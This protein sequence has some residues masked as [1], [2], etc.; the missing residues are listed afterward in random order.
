VPI[1]PLCLFGVLALSSLTL[2]AAED[3]DLKSIEHKQP[4][5]DEAR[6]YDAWIGRSAALLAAQW[7]APADHYEIDGFSYVRYDLP[8]G[9]CHTV[10]QVLD[11]KVTAWRQYGK[12][13]R[14]P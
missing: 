7:G 9:D 5:A 2:R 3:Y 8:V 10:F 11:R 6:A 14:V 12:T 1:K 4:P 13:C